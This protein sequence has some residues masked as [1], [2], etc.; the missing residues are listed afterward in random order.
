[1]HKSEKFLTTLFKGAA[2]AGYQFEDSE[3]VREATAQYSPDTG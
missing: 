1:L 2:A 3:L